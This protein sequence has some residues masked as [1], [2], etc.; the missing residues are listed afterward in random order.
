[1]KRLILYI[2]FIAFTTNKT[3]A[4]QKTP[5]NWYLQSSITDSMHGISLNA[6]YQFLKDKK[7][8]PIIVAVIDGGIDTTHEDL[9]NVLWR[10]PK[11]IPGNGID[12]DHNGYVDDIYGWNFLG[13]KDSNMTKAVE[14][15]VRIFYKYKPEFENKNI[16]EPNLNP[17][18]K[19]LYQQWKLAVKAMTV[20]EEEVQQIFFLEMATKAI[21]K[22]DSIL[23]KDWSH[24]EY[25]AEELEK[26]NP[27]NEDAQKGK[28]GYLDFIS[29]GR[30]PK[31]MK[32]TAL[33]KELDEYIS[34]RKEFFELA[35]NPPLDYRAQTVKDDVEDINDHNYGNG[36][37]MVNNPLHG[38]HVSGI[39]AAQ[40]NNG[41]G[42]D[43]IADNVKIMAIRAV[44]DGDEYDKDIALAIRY[45]V[46]NGA[47]VVNMSFGKGFSPHKKWVDEAIKYAASKDVLLVHAAG[48]DAAN[49]DSTRNFP[50]PKYFGTTTVAPNFITVGAS[51]D[52]L[53]DSSLTASFSNYGKTTVDVFA[54][55]STIYSTLPGNKYGNESGTSMA[56]PVVAGVAALIRSYFPKLT[57][58]Q[59]KQIIEQS[60][61]IPKTTDIILKPA[62][63]KHVLMSTLCKSKGIVNAE[64]AVKLAAKIAGSN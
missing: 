49:N 42:I 6:A 7:S 41:I 28:T 62:T 22:Y 61:F 4:Q 47:K 17:E 23:Q 40:R 3:V 25:S 54:P 44:P 1:M 53:I 38:T 55:G 27:T 26:Y 34:N 21:K 8:I 45:A 48:N 18:K 32:N 5:H 60:V 10:N 37:V 35:K 14:E 46:D 50:N 36:N 31:D 33:I 11:E 29:R 13:N 20:S 57:A 30:I 24:N 16:N 58:K 12:D 19:E 59:V 56:S 9:K 64:A 39:I 63:K 43:G 51:S 2:L 15:K 52:F